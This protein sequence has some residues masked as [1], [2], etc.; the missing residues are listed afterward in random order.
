MN[1]LHLCHW[2]NISHFRK[3][4]SLMSNLDSVVIFGKVT[5]DE[6]K[7]ITAAT[8]DIGINWYLVKEHNDPNIPNAGDKHE[9]SHDQW[10]ELVI[11]HNNT[12]AW[13]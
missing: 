12:Y 11:K 1:T 13:K 2:L 6:Q 4:L 9:I 3:H 8:Q 7:Q 5:V 10:L